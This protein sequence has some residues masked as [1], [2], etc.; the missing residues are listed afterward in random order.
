MITFL[1]VFED[2]ACRFLTDASCADIA[3]DKK[4]EKVAERYF[5][6]SVKVKQERKKEE[7]ILPQRALLR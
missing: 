1:I 7:Y 2:S 6:I 3:K 5:F 4:N